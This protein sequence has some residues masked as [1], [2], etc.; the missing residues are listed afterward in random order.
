MSCK[1]SGNVRDSIL[2]HGRSV[3]NS[4]PNPDHSPAAV[5][6]AVVVGI[7]PYVVIS[8]LEEMNFFLKFGKRDEQMV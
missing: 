7:V 1:L 5:V 4:G 2:S 3:P 6:V 8:S